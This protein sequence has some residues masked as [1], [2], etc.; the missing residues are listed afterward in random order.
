M[1]LETADEAHIL[2][3]HYL[4]FLADFCNQHDRVA[5]ALKATRSPKGNPKASPTDQVRVYG[6]LVLTH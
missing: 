1:S 5:P 3:L 4:Q 2:F 6:R